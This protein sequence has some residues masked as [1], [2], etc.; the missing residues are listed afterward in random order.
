MRGRMHKKKTAFVILLSIVFVIALSK[1]A[2]KTIK[3]YSSDYDQVA[4]NKNMEA[5]S[6]KVKQSNDDVLKL[7]LENGKNNPKAYKILENVQSYPRELLELASKKEEALNFVADYTDYKGYS[8]IKASVRKDYKK[9]EIPLFIQWDKR[10]GYEKYGS[11]FIAINGCGTTS[12]AMVAV[13]LTGNTNINPKVVADYSNDKGYLVEGVGT[14]WDLMTQGA[15][16]FGIAG[17][18]ISLSEE[19]ILQ[20]LRKGQPIIVSMGPGEFTT[21]GHYIVL[22]GVD[23]NNKIIVNDPDSKLKSKKTWDINI[24][25]KEAKNLWAFKAL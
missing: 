17:R 20:T 16:K 9:G 5:I 15:R 23:S 2:G 3:A 18:E 25:L 10:W 19:S 12:I 14:S 7:I 24:F 6:E 13:G 8:K 1:I 11:D 4:M 22:T 21:S